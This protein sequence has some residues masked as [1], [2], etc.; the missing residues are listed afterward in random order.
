ML[1]FYGLRA[2]LEYDCFNDVLSLH[3]FECEKTWNAV[4]QKIEEILTDADDKRLLR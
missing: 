4:V 1:T 3:K 2:E